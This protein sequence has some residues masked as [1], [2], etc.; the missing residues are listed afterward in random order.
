MVSRL[1]LQQTN[2]IAFACLV[3]NKGDP[4]KAKRKMVPTPK[5]GTKSMPTHLFPSLGPPLAVFQVEHG[6]VGGLG[7]HWNQPGGG[8][9]GRKWGGGGQWKRPPLNRDP[10]KKKDGFFKKRDS[11]HETLEK[12]QRLDLA[13]PESA[14]LEQ[15]APVV[16][17]GG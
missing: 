6:L 2:M 11:K 14:E 10:R 4:K 1:E 5:K 8:G 9:G 7:E 13:C 3:E 17:A 16:V 12:G 15:S